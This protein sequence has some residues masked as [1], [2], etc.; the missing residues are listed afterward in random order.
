MTA[1]IIDTETTDATD[2]RELIEAAYMPVTIEMREAVRSALHFKQRYK[3]LQPIS[4]GAMA[5][6]HI[7]PSDLDGMPPPSDFDWETI[8]RPDVKRICTLA[9]ARRLW[10]DTSHTLSALM[11]Q[12]SHDLE[13]TRYELRG[14]HNAMADVVF[15]WRR[16]DDIDPYLRKAFEQR[17]KR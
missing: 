12:F 10:P 1:L 8:G 2:D 4:F 16:Q 5:T 11:Y 17:F 13:A 7:L 9:I 3:P 15:C 6:H 14:A